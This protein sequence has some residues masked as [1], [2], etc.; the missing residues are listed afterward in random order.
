MLMSFAG[1]P[2]TGKTTIARHLSQTTGAVY[3]RVDEIDAAIWAIDPDRD[4]GP[5]SYHIAAA[6]AASNLALGHRVIVDCVTPW[7]ITRKIFTEAATRA[8]VRLLGIETR[9][10]DPLVHR[11]RVEE[12]IIDV[13]GLEKP[14]WQKVMSRD[15]TPWD[16]AD[17]RLDTA[18]L[19]VMQ[20]VA[21][22]E[23]RLS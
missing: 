5:E 23:A 16:K 13:P 1:L 12:R 7:A 2:G 22:I 6:L 20:A 14:D 4:I 11:A 9:C 18:Q 8:R 3:L 17:L 19:S 15:Y 21:E 10:S